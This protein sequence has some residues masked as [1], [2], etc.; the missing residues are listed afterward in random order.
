[1]PCTSSLTSIWSFMFI[2]VHTEP[3]HN[4]NLSICPPRACIK[5]LK[6]EEEEEQAAD[7]DMASKNERPSSPY[8][9]RL[10]LQSSNHTVKVGVDN[11]RFSIRLFLHS[12]SKLVRLFHAPCT[13]NSHRCM[14]S[15][16][17]SYRPRRNLHAVLALD[18]SSPRLLV[19]S[20]LPLCR[21]TNGKVNT[22]T[23]L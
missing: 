16:T 4:R 6:E 11:I 21:E 20:A 7:R 9:C 17:Y 22:A 5:R 19:R 2:H 14:R 10:G 18:P 13:Q 1:M 23:T 3:F 8:C 15:P 12:F